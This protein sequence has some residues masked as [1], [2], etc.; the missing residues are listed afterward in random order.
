MIA[1]G[2]GHN[3]A[4]SAAFSVL[5]E[6][7]FL[8]KKTDSFLA[9]AGKTINDLEWLINGLSTSSFVH[10]KVQKIRRGD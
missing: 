4:F 5:G 10:N 8:T 9:K 6:L 2:N 7:P 1:V 3:K